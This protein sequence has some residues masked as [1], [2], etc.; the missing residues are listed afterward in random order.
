MS[1]LAGEPRSIGEQAPRLFAFRERLAK[2]FDGSQQFGDGLVR[3]GF[4]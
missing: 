1:W 2:R 4:E 3:L